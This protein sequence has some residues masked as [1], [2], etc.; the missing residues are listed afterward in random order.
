M[1][2]IKRIVTLMLA[3]VTAVT[4]FMGI[5]LPQN[6]K[7]ADS[8]RV[9]TWA[10]GEYIQDKSALHSEDFDI[11][12]D[13]ILFH[14]ATFD[15]EGKVD[16][17]KEELTVALSN[18]REVIGDRDVK[19]TLNLLGP[20][21]HT[22]S[23]VW[24]DRMEAQSDAHNKAFKSGVLED[25]IVAVLDEYKLDGVHFD[26]EYPLS[27]KAWRHFNKFLV[28]LDKKLGDYTLGVAAVEW[29]LKFSNAALK[30]VDSIE[31]MM[32]D[33]YDDEG[34]HATTET[35]KEL[36]KKV[37]LRAVPLEKVT[38]GLPFYARP[39]DRDSY[40]F[41][42][43]GYY[44]QIDENGWYHDEAL[45]K[46]FWFNTPDVIYEKTDFAINEGYSGVM[47]WHYTCD[48]PAGDSASLTGA[49][50]RAVNDN[51]Q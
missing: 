20:G 1:F 7:K 26:Y 10:V 8:F 19:I 12:T 46:D 21:G 3:V 14:C 9:K 2:C 43:N 5:S 17:E 34:K 45:N 32:Y 11:I 35:V 13:V 33:V 28:S 23:E 37:G 51:Y 47:I 27:L 15:E 49:I 48:L 22:D 39:S 16:V 31:L 4:S 6:D 41:G 25:N 18:L 42:Y 30:A 40:W 38:L 50:G 36:V 44:T 24:E 29:N